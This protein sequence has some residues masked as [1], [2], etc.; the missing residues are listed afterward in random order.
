MLRTQ[1]EVSQVRAEIEKRIAEKEE[2]FENTRYYRQ[3]II[4]SLI[5]SIVVDHYSKNHQRSLDS[6]QASLESE[7]KSRAELLRVKKKL[8][9]DINELEV[10]LD[11]A[12]KA[13]ADAQKNIKL[14]SDK[15]KELQTQV[16]VEQRDTTQ[17]REQYSLTEKRVA[18][19][20]S[21]KEE[22]ASA[23]S[24]VKNNWDTK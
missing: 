15:I 23:L 22:V 10:A 3:Q 11:H 24:Q 9:S 5:D 12:N 20:Y 13:N 7:A 19:L 18:L 14:H 21:E 4:L 17:I 16:E 1:I 6:M 2:E 8:E